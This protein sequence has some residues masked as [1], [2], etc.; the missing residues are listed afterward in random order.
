MIEINLERKYL[1]M[2]LV[3]GLNAFQIEFMHEGK[4]D[5][6][7]EMSRRNSEWWK[8]KIDERPQRWKNTD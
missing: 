3:I 8:K 2:N 4:A 7:E 1:L 6:G 5:S